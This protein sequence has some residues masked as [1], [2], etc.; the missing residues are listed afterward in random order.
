MPSTFVKEDIVIP[1]GGINND[2]IPIK[3]FQLSDLLSLVE[4]DYKAGDI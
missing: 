1:I 3:P 2:Q 4:K